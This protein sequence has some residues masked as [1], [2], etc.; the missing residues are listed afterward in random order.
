MQKLFFSA[1]NSWCW[2][3]IVVGLTG[4]GVLLGMVAY[5]VVGGVV[6]W[7]VA[8]GLALIGAY[9][10]FRTASYAR[11]RNQLVEFAHGQ[12]PS[13]NSHAQPQDH[14]DQ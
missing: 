8:V 5:F 4:L 3:R 7:V 6:G 10:G 1:I 9:F 13:T 2:L 12:A 11:R 14:E